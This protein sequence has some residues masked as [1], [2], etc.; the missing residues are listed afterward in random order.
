MQPVSRSRLPVRF[1]IFGL[2]VAALALTGLVSGIG[3]VWTVLF[4]RV[5][6]TCDVL[7]QPPGTDCGSGDVTLWVAA[8]IGMFVAGLVGSA[9]ALQRTRR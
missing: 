3:L 4:A 8:A 5:W 7:P 9:F 6:L 2:V 1:G